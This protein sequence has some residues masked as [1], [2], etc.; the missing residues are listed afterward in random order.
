ML[1]GFDPHLLLD[2]FRIHWVSGLF[3]LLTLGTLLLIVIIRILVR[4]H[5]KRLLVEE[6][7]EEGELDLLT[8]L[9]PKDHDALALVKEMR[10]EIWE[11]PDVELQFNIEALNQRAFQVV[12]SVAAV[13]HPAEEAPQY[14]AS[15]LELLQL[16]R[17]VVSRIQRIAGVAPFRYLGT[18]KLSDYQRYYEVYRKINDNPILQTLKRHPTIFKLARWAMNL[19]NLTNPIYWASRELSREGYFFMV[20]WFH[21]TFVSQVGREAIRLYSGRHFQSEVDRD[22]VLVFYRLFALTRRWGG[23]SG[24][25]WPIL[26]EF[27]TGHAGVEVEGKLHILSRWSQNR[28]PKDLDELD[29]QTPLG[30][31]WYRKGLKVLL[32]RDEDAAPGRRKI[33]EAELARIKEKDQ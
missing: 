1:S 21:L 11:L 30:R 31:R 22:A 7:E 25:D 26:V 18:R 23:P 15:L 2:L 27:L 9:G 8:P 33:I 5:T 10:R 17:R 20:R 6:M 32:E 19:K 29:L 12:R 14:E 28:L 3:L 4:R 24:E 16:M 13:Y